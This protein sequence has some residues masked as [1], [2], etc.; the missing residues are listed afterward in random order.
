VIH[1]LAVSGYRSIR[2]LVVPLSQLTM[3]T[4][5]N[6]S[7]K[8]SFYRSLRLLGE[9]AQGRA[10]SALAREGGLA[11]TLWAGP[12][13][14][15]RAM[16]AGDVPIQGTVR[17][18]RVALKLGFACDDFGYAIDLGLPIP[19]RTSLF[20]R[21]PDIKAEAVWAGEQLSRRNMIASRTGPMVTSLNAGGRRQQ[22][23]ATLSPWD[24]MLTH[25]ADPVAFPEL[26][27]M[28]E[29][30]R[31]WRFYDH[32]R[33]DAE[34][35]A[36]SA[37]IGTRTPVLA[38]DGADLAAAIR[39]I[40]EIGDPDQLAMTVDAAF[41]GSAIDVVSRDGLF[42]LSMRQHGLLR[43]LGAQELSDGTLRYLLLVAA[44]LT[45]R[46]PELM[47][48]NEP[49]TSLHPELLGPLA[50]MIAAASSRSQ[51]VV[52]THSPELVSALTRSG[53]LRHNLA[54]TLGETRIDGVEPVGWTWP[55]RH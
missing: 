14:I 19:D 16:E 44:L 31:G 20:N 34:A 5:A 21:D 42:D 43:P 50:E 26:S 48:L 15:T 30:M 35:A 33:T 45:P 37:Q 49:E 27:I 8:S 3:I 32:F 13:S 25:A 22:I 18:E 2:D 17:R 29:R 11:S 39:T 47:V 53:V 54:K 12:E 41:P 7:G 24:S 4:G 51:I 38:G 55:S 6:G 52:V 9:I 40:M 1:T 46:P 10:V 36:R 28:R 23:T